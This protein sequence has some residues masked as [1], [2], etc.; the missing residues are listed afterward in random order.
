VVPRVGDADVIL[1][2]D[3]DLISSAPG[4]LAHARGFAA[5]R[6]P[7]RTRQMSRVYAIEPTP[8]LIGAAADHRVIAHPRQ[9]F[10]VVHALA[11]G[12]LRHETVPEQFAAIID[13]LKAARGRALVHAGPDVPAESI[14]LI[15]AVNEA[16]GGRGTT[17]DVLEPV[18]HKPTDHG[19]SLRALVRDMHDGHVE[20]LVVIGTNPVFTAPRSVGFTEA[21][22][23]VPFM[24]ALAPSANETTAAATWAVPQTHD[25]ESWGD[26]RAFDG[27]ATIMQPQSLPLYG[28]WSVHALMSLL[29]GPDSV[30]SR[31]AVRETWRGLDDSAWR[32][33]LAAGVVGDTASARADVTLRDLSRC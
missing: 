22:R 10:D 27:T 24:L 1:A 4:H 13:D 23:R 31:D 5:R 20:T 18:E 19:D 3:S 26:A 28:G 29:T 17:F 25:W 8:T 16:L 9:L 7:L 12:V 2:L 6:N 11:A 15:H 14:A 30:G 33:A 32:E 21:L